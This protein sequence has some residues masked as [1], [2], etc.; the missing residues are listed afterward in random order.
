[1]VVVARLAIVPLLAAGCGEGSVDTPVDGGAD[2]DTDGGGACPGGCPDGEVCREGRCVDPEAL[3][4]GVTCPAGQRCYLGECISG[5]PCDGVVCSN[6]GEVC[7]NG[8]CVAGEADADGDGAQAR[9]DCDDSDPEIHPGAI[10][11]CNGED[12]DCDDA[13]DESFDLDGDGF[14]GC[15]HSPVEIRDCDDENAW[16]HPGAEEDCNGVDD[17]CDGTGDEDDPGGGEPCGESTGACEA[18][19]SQCVGGEIECL[20]AIWPRDEVC[21][22]ADDD[23]NGTNDD[24]EAAA[25]CAPMAH[26]TVGCVG[27]ACHLTAC[28]E[29]WANLNPSEADGCETPIDAHADVCGSATDLGAIGDTGARADVQGTVAPAGD[30]DW[31]TFVA[32]D[33]AD[34]SCDQFHLR[35]EFVT[36]PGNAYSFE[37]R[38][39][40]CR[41]AAECGAT[42]VGTYEFFTDMYADGPWG[43]EIR[44]ECP[45]GGGA[46]QNR[47]SD[48]S[49]AYRVRIFRRDG[50]TSPEQYLLRISNG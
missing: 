49:A 21:N 32:T 41:A 34:G 45:C 44:G 31:V 50:G 29:G 16:V 13:I 18:G 14:P 20:G 36:N 47:C 38:R 15:E 10:E 1:L 3:C 39:G 22:G 30:V 28:D 11:R 6:P 48:N 25:S 4:A 27:G 9:D 7:Q 43:A 42:E 33:G 12:D 26:G 40:D 46:G 19:L 23:C 37:V 24:G 5:D 17:D 35:I 8:D 2:G